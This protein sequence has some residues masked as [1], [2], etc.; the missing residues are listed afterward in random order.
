M[1]TAVDRNFEN[2][3][4]REISKLGEIPQQYL[5]SILPTFIN[6]I[7]RIISALDRRNIPK[8]QGAPLHYNPANECTM[9]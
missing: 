3:S 5:S 1:D 2:R 4:Y 9:Q 8:A 6:R 7:V